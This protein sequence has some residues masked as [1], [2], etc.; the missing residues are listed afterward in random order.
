MLSQNA[1]RFP[2]DM[3]QTAVPKLNL[4]LNFKLHFSCWPFMCPV[5][6]MYLII[7]SYIPF[8]INEYIQRIQRLLSVE[9]N[10]FPL[11]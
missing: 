3:G 9:L 1:V 10:T 6:M 5:C 8:C 7:L 2:K 11:T 4:R